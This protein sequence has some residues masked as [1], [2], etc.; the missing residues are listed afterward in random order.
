M[1]KYCYTKEQKSFIESMRVPYAVYQFVDKRV[2]TIALS[3]G[4]CRLFGYEGFAEAYRDMDNDMYKDTHPDDIA[5]IAN[6]ALR[7]ATEG[8]RYETIYRTKVAGGPGY[9]I[10]HAYGEHVY[11]EAGVQ[12]AQIWYSDEG[13]YVEECGQSGNRLNQSLSNA[14]HENSLVKASQYDYLTGLPNMTYFFELAE[15][16]KARVWEESGTPALLY[17]DFSGMKF[18][19]TKYGFAEGDKL[20]QAFA[21]ELAE[22][23]G[24]EH[25]CRIGSDHFAVQTK[26]EGLDKTLKKM[27]AECKKMNGGKTLPIH[28]G[29][30]VAQ[31]NEAVHTSVACD[32]ARLACKALN[33]KYAT[34]VKYY[35][36]GL[37]E[38]AAK[39][40]Y[41]VENIDRALAENWIRV[42]FQPIIRA[43]NGRVC[44]VEALARWV[45]PEK[46]FLSPADF[47]PALED[48]GL[49]YRLDLYIVDRVLEVIKLRLYENEIVVPHSVNLSRS[50]FDACDIV[51]EIRKRVDDAGIRRDLITI[52]ITESIIGSD[53]DFMKKQVERFQRLGFPVWMDDFGSGYS[54]LDVLQS[55]KFDL[56]KFDMSFLRRLD[57]GNAGKV[58][59]TDMMRMATSLGV[60]TV[61]E[62]VETEEQV[63]FLQEIG[64][65]KLQGY[66]YSKPMPFVRV[67]E[68]REKRSVLES[69]DP[70][71]SAYYEKVGRVNLFDLGVI[72]GEAEN[73]LRNT[74][75]TIPI[76]VLEAHGDTAHYIR[77]NRSYRYLA[78]RFLGIDITGESIETA[79]SERVNWLR[80]IP[81]LK[82]CCKTGQHVFF[83][84]KAPDGSVFHFFMRRIA[85]N[86]IT[87]STSVAIAVLSV[88]DPEESTTF[89]EIARSL[90]ANYYNIFVID[91]DKNEYIE[92]S[93]KA[94]GEELSIERR[95]EDFFESAKAAAEERVYKEDR[96]AF[97]TVFTKDV[98]LRELESQGVF[99]T[100]YRV[101]DSGTPTYVQMKVTRMHGGNR[102]ILGISNVDAYIRQKKLFD[103][104]RKEREALVRVM[105]LSD[106][107]LSLFTV[108]PT[109]G[110]YVE[111]SSSE[112]FD[113]LGAAK[114]GEDFFGQAYEDAFT[115]CYEED[116]ARF[117]EQFTLENV[118]R[119]IRTGGSYKIDYRLL[120][121][122]EPKPVTLKAA[123]IHEGGE[124]KLVVGVRAW[125]DRITR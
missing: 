119:E 47:I 97:L 35:E 84:E 61:C 85:I 76:A 122:G 36:K 72:A 104:M 41:V 78:K 25:S 108:N 103:E 59:L 18:Y 87:K 27:L 83:E 38:D 37:S 113:S 15:A 91:L 9:R 34:A 4:F 100:I 67:Q 115:V 125:R 21:K 65:S 123:L 22:T 66:Y 1:K 110:Q 71:E 50:D 53:F 19:N 90:A 107:Y 16:D 70:E 89:A 118:M 51:E 46:G 120:I 99:T 74:F 42:Y 111:F 106:G 114:Q 48:A 3:A 64:C 39:K 98:V 68:M 7:F 12:L 102:L 105:A 8:G 29:V 80:F 55:I 2:V 57:E 49:I 30:Y 31:A 81:A 94:G 44:D 77:S 121:N 62:G 95:G 79:V 69:E 23:F 10:I 56:L 88:T 43:V 5:R 86:Q 26:T 14:L 101:V 109:S 58:I 45:D 40:Q 124:E 117:Q 60:D 17:I 6:D 33:G 96:E 54:S 24:N 52:E 13:I 75:S 73:A 20:L 93:S 32:R 112:A 28:V 116:R 11:P 82:K 92:Y 63:R